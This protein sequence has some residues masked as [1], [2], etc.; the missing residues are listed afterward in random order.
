MGF[1]A[2]YRSQNR[3]VARYAN[4]KVKAMDTCAGLNQTHRRE[5]TLLERENRI[6]IG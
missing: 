2:G 1:L 6:A 3:P 4:V 5:E